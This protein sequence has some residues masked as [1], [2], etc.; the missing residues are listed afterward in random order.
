MAEDTAL[1]CPECKDRGHSGAAKIGN[2]RSAC[3]TC[4]QFAQAVARR[5][6]TTLRSNH[7]DEVARLRATIEADLYAEVR[8][9]QP[10]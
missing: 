5:I 10:R 4:N 7:P 3:A 1:Q 9:R 2:R 6:C 8:E